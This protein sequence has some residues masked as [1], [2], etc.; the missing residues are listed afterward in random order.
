VR[1]WK[2]IHRLT[3]KDLAALAGE[4]CDNAR[5][6][7][8]QLLLRV[9]LPVSMGGMGIRPVERIMHAAYLASLLESLPE[10]LRLRT[11]LQT[12]EGRAAHA[13]VSVIFEEIRGLLEKLEVDGLS[14]AM[15]NRRGRRA[16]E[17][18]T[19]TARGISAPSHGFSAQRS[20][21]A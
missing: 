11:H 6:T 12:A 3:D 7:A 18:A 13:R 10:L 21:S 5:V 15:A 17:Q 9:S 2:T 20:Y 4:D 8:E 1:C 14:L 19:A 16:A